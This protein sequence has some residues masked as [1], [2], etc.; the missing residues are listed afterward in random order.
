MA[1]PRLVQNQLNPL[2]DLPPPS[3]V[4]AEK[5]ILG[6]ILLDNSL[7]AKARE[8]L[9]PGEFFLHSHQK[10]Y[11]KMLVLFE[12]GSVIDIVTLPDELRRAGEFEDVGGA[13]YIASLIDGVPRTDNIEHYVRMVKAK[14]LIRRVIH[15]CTNTVREGLSDQVPGLE[16]V[17]ALT[18]QL[19]RIS[20]QYTE[21]S[22]P[23]DVARLGLRSAVAFVEE[24]DRRF[25]EAESDTV[26]VG[27]FPLGFHADIQFL[28][29]ETTLWAGITTHGKSTVV[30][31][32][33]LD[34]ILL[35]NEKAAV[36]SFEQA[37]P[38]S[39]YVMLRQAAGRRYVDRETRRRILRW[40]GQR[41]WIF[42]L[43]GTA[44]SQ[45]VFKIFRY[46][47]EHYGVT[48]FFVD[49]LGKISD[50]AS[51]DW[52]G[53]ARFMNDLGDFAVK[54]DCHAHLVH[55]IKD[56]EGNL[57]VPRLSDI[58][59]AGELVNHAHNV[60]IIHKNLLRQDRA[61][62]ANQKGRDAK[63]DSDLDYDVILRTGKLKRPGVPPIPDLKLHW[64]WQSLL[65]MLRKTDNPLMYYNA[66]PEEVP[67]D[68][69]YDERWEDM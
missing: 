19:E 39:L 69:K 17:T 30:S 27:A 26:P 62:R 12:C 5:S 16:L 41:L 28:R 7:C 51:D 9:S 66:I 1:R 31:Q 65:C 35:H 22:N 58:K 46:A 56:K 32:G 23:D 54:Y 18:E 4:E 42:D 15:A 8:W 40:L 11:R 59:G 50:I 29:G 47:R 14:A 20:T 43:V 10:L 45:R 37:P 49:C 55:H 44:K 53:Q 60:L 24:V 67:E 48:H 3:N 21:V 52:S 61:D 57:Y 36:A 63:V 34:G 64:H 13:T 68:Y 38:A 6:A 2:F 25:E 33:I